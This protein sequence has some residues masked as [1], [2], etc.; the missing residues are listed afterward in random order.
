MEAAL[1]AFR[2]F[3]I[4][5]K[6]ASE[7]TVRAYLRDLDELLSFARRTLGRAP[8]LD[9]QSWTNTFREE[10]ALRRAGFVSQARAACRRA[11][12]SNPIEPELTYGACADAG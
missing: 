9:Q 2:Q 5:E 8:E 11:I 6:R 12:A 4:A 1:A 3:L 7:H 10:R